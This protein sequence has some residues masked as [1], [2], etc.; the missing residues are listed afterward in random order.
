MVLKFFLQRLTSN[1]GLP[2]VLEFRNRV[3]VCY[4]ASSRFILPSPLPMS[5]CS[6]RSGFAFLR[7][8]LLEYIVPIATTFQ[9]IYWVDKRSMISTPYPIRRIAGRFCRDCVAFNRLAILGCFSVIRASEMARFRAR[10]GAGIRRWKNALLYTFYWVHSRVRH[11]NIALF[12]TPLERTDSP[13]L[14]CM[15]CI[16]ICMVA[17]AVAF[18]VWTMAAPNYVN[19][20]SHTSHGFCA[21]FRCFC[22]AFTHKSKRPCDIN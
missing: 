16:R 2:P 21:C 9:L 5:Q 12:C 17:Y 7:T 3:M 6:E 8:I 13:L 4:F 14:R 20:S 18:G 15:F 19:A 11:P 1:P 10:F 22:I